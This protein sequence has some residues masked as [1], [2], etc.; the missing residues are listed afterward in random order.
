MLG[1]KERMSV[2]CVHLYVCVSVCVHEL[3]EAWSRVAISHEFHFQAFLKISDT[4]N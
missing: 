3:V 4:S 1:E 2:F